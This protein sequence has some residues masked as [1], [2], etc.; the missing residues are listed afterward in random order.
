MYEIIVTGTDGSDTATEAVKAAAALAVTH[1]ADLHIVSVVSPMSA[2]LAAQGAP[3]PPNWTESQHQEAATALSR[4]GGLARDLGAKV[5]EHALDGDPATTII[6]LAENLKADLIVVG[7]RGMKGLGRFV[8]GSVPNRI[9][10]HAPCSVL[11]VRT[12]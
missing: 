5:H 7:N 6:A 4:V 9:A 3:L 12:T 10:H 1:N 2:A 8:L 11:I